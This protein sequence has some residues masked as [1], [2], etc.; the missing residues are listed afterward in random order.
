MKLTAQAFKALPKK[1][2]TLLGMSGSGKTYITG[3]L[4]D[5]GWEGYSCDYQ[6]GAKFLKEDL[7]RSEGFSAQDIRALSHFIGKLGNPDLGG[8]ELDLFLK[9]QKAYYDAE[10]KAIAEAALLCGQSA[11][12]FVHDSTGSLC[13]ILDDA[14]IDQIGQN[15]L[16][17]YL[18]ADAQGE[19]EVLQRAQDYPKPLFFPPNDLSRWI[20]EYMQQNALNEVLDIVPDDFSRW[21]FPKLFQ[22]RK[23][24][25]QKLAD[26]YGVTIESKCFLGIKNSDDFIDI[27]AE[28]LE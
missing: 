5:Y 11:G 26:R 14:L 6:I 13:E 9:R 8:Y 4:Q 21:V 25:Y 20:E 16:F 18:K 24:K 22:S 28:H 7:R 17:V 27:V 2:I 12:H 15:S 1:R 23:P 19:K 3:Y 10:C